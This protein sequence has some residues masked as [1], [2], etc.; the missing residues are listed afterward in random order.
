MKPENTEERKARRKRSA[1]RGVLLFALLQLACAVCFGALCFIPDMPGWCVIL[2]G[3]L[4]ALFALNYLLVPLILM[5]VP[6][7]TL[8]ADEREYMKNKEHDLRMDKTMGIILLCLS[9][10]AFLLWEF[11]L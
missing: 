4:A 7:R 5:F 8:P 10:A 1:V 9:A 11:L 2:F 6:W 3:V